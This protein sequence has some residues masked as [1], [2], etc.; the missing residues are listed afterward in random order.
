MTV[1]NGLYKYLRF[2]AYFT[3]IT[4]VNCYS[5]QIHWFSKVARFN[6]LFIGTVTGGV[7]F[8]II[9]FTHSM[10]GP[11]ELFPV[12]TSVTK[13]MVCVILSVGWCI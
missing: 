8:N 6:K 4:L 3:Y 5:V 13:A 1:S 10:M 7:A 2:I 11:C 9:V 12:P